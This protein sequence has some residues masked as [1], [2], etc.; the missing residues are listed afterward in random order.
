M[1]KR[2]LD[3]KRPDVAIAIELGWKFCGLSGG[4]HLQFEHPLYPRK[5][6]LPATPSDNRSIRNGVAWIK[7]STPREDGSIGTASLRT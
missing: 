6:T 1:A 2:K 5:M 7:R 3:K 4:S